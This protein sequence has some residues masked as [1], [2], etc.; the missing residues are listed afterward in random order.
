MSSQKPLPQTSKIKH[1]KLYNSSPHSKIY[2]IHPIP[3]PCS[4]PSFPVLRRP[5][6]VLRPLPHSAPSL[7][8]C[9]ELVAAPIRPICPIPFL[10]FLRRPRRSPYL[11]HST[12]LYSPTL[13]TLLTLK[14]LPC[15]AASSPLCALHFPLSFSHKNK[16]MTKLWDNSTKSTNFVATNPN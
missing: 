8:F 13:K 5:F 1:P 12:Y 6:P 16:K 14:T 9:G 15:P 2:P 3:L 10:L 11:P 7:L 4:V